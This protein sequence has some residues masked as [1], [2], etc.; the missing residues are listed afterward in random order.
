MIKG[1]WDI[2]KSTHKVEE[3]TYKVNKIKGQTAKEEA[4]IATLRESDY[5]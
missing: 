5:Y 4:I 1:S 2:A 3:G